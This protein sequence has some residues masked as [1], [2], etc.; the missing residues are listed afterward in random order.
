MTSSLQSILSENY[1]ENRDYE[2]E[3]KIVSC[4]KYGNEKVFLEIQEYL[5]IGNEAL[6]SNI[7]SMPGIME[8]IKHFESLNNPLI[9]WCNVVRLLESENNEKYLYLNEN[10]ITTK[11]IKLIEMGY[12]DYIINTLKQQSYDPVEFFEKVN[13]HTGKISIFFKE[14]KNDIFDKI[15]KSLDIKFNRTN[16]CIN[17][18]YQCLLN[19]NHYPFPFPSTYQ[20]FKLIGKFFEI[21]ENK[22]LINIWEEIQFRS[23]K[24]ISA[25]MNLMQCKETYSEIPEKIK[26]DSIKK[27]QYALNEI[28]NVSKNNIKK[29]I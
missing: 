12:S 4:F 27:E 6:I 24:S 1:Q 21:N 19:K 23:N 15:E 5:P 17:F 9:D 14:N 8:K 22:D 3:D 11:F 16:L 10:R 13:H 29:R 20:E 2:L 26:Q 25:K 28:L 18:I 7:L